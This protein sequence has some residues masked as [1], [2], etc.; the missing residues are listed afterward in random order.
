[1][2]KSDK[3]LDDMLD[4]VMHEMKDM[5]D[6]FSLQMGKY[7][8]INELEDRIDDLEKRVKKIEEVKL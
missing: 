3:T 4:E 2:T 1:M 7:E 5:R 8:Q 6:E